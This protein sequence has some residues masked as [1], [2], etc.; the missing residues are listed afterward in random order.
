MEV[1]KEIS[2][3]LKPATIKKLLILEK[4]RKGVQ[5]NKLVFVG[6]TNL[7]NYYWCSMKS[8]LASYENEIEFFASYIID[9]LCYS[10]KLGLIDKIPTDL[11]KILYIGDDIKFEDIEKLL[12]EQEKEMETKIS[13]IRLNGIGL[14]NEVGKKI[15]YVNPEIPE[16]ELQMYK[17]IGYELRNL[18]EAPP[19]LRGDVLHWIKTENYPTIRW[20]FPWKNYVIVGV[21]DG[22]KSEF[23]YEY[24]TTRTAFLVRYVRP[25]AFAQA[26]LYGYFFRRPKKRVQIYIVDKRKVITWETEVDKRAAEE[27][28]LKFK[29]LDEGQEPL[30]PKKWK[31]K[32]CEYKNN[33]KVKPI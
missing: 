16:I 29:V 18:G 14:K 23:V 11:N 1:Y 32:Y 30:L 10:L 7:A 22:I 21:P 31:C 25:V 20:N 2:W 28:L 3:I 8:L 19:M 12:K 6:M 13:K 33:C 9:R 26:D 27:L 15:L 24:K 17:H 5:P 4:E